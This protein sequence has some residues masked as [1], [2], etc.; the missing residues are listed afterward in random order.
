[1]E[2]SSNAFALFMYGL[3]AD[4][5]RR[6]Y[7]ARLKR[8]FGFIGVG[9]ATLEEQCENFA[10]QPR[11]DLN[12]AFGSIIRFLGDMNDKARKKE[13]TFGTVKNYYKS[14]KKFYDM[15]SLNLNWKL[16]SSGLLPSRK[17]A[18]DRAPTKEEIRRLVEYPDLRI[19]AIV[20]RVRRR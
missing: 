20:S 2:F 16:V 18:N 10:H 17:S 12:Y 7:L 19:K 4:D 11:Q 1:M 5:T 13:I 14:I 15:N 6:Q 8:F 3:K 9:G